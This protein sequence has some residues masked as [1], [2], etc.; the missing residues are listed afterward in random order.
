MIASLHFHG[1][2]FLS[3]FFSISF[4]FTVLFCVVAKKNHKKFKKNCFEKNRKIQKNQKSQKKIRKKTTQKNE[5][6][7]CLEF[8]KIPHIYQVTA[9]RKLTSCVSGTCANLGQVNLGRV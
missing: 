8:L 4:T 6:F 9:I 5:H 1:K 7:T 2:Y 3:V